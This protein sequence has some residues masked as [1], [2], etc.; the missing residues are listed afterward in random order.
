MG[1]ETALG[2]NILTTKVSDLAN[3]A[4][5]NSLWPMPF[6]TAC[7]AI[8][9]MSVVSAHYDLARFGAEVVRFSPRQSDLLMVM[10]TITDKMGPVLKKIYDQMAEPKWV[11]CMGACATSG[12]FYRAYHVMQGIDEIIPVDV[13]IP[14]CPPS[15]EAVLQAVIM[16]Q[17]LIE[18]EK[19]I[20]F[21]ARQTIREQLKKEVTE[22]APKPLLIADT[23]ALEATRLVQITREPAAPENATVAALKKEYPGEI[24]DVNDFRGDL[25]V[26]VRPG[27]VVDICRTLKTDPS[28]KFNLLSTITGIDYKGYPD[29]S[30]DE[31]FSV[32]YHM[33]SV[34]SGNRVRLK[35]PLP[36]SSPEIE[37]VTPIWKTANWWE[38]ET[39]DMFGVRFRN[40]PDLRRILCHEEF[41]GYAL[42]KDHD[43]GGRTPLSHDYKLPIENMLEWRPDENPDRLTGQPT[44]INIGPS[45]P[46]TH[47]TLRIVCRLDG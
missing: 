43:P 42:R 27:R 24:L 21:D 22:T 14:G 29:K 28:L 6:G 39:F 31:R 23:Q 47:G 12:G 36:E 40:H 9:F 5:K 3:W 10:G 44:I 46:A 4:R 34:D 2:D 32:V 7:C 38:R 15:P 25:A 17:K 16:I 11:L 1:I 45:H 30:K 20:D 13:Y 8:E 18:K 35:V 33:Y 26:T 37:T 19:E 41:V